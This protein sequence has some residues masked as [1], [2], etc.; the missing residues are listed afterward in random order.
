MINRLLNA[1]PVT[2][3]WFGLVLWLSFLVEVYR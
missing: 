2:V 1:Y 3:L